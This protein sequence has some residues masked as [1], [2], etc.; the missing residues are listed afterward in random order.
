MKKEEGVTGQAQ[1]RKLGPRKR[2]PIQMASDTAIKALI[3][4]GFS[5]RKAAEFMD[6]SPTTVMRVRKE[7]MAQAQPSEISGL[8]S[9]QRDEKTAKLI[10][11]FLDKGLKMRK[12]KPSDAIGVAKLYADR[13]YP[14]RSEAPAPPRTFVNVDLSIF[15][16]DPQPAPRE[17]DLEAVA[18]DE[19]PEGTR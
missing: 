5:V 7:M 6:I 19:P 11:H 4:K 12:I 15:L 14:V 18:V 13:R 3:T 2:N 10:D 1:S 17:I 8:L 9:P 16:P